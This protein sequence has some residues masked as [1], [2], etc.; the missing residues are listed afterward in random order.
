M[1]HIEECKSLC[2]PGG[3]QTMLQE[4]PLPALPASSFP[5]VVENEANANFQQVSVSLDAILYGHTICRSS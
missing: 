5:P 4:P 3:A 2:V 1:D